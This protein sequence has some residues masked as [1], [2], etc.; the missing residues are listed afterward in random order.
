VNNSADR[1][2]QKEIKNTLKIKS[3]LLNNTHNKNF[4]TN[5]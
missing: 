3:F 4:I 2:M 1:P 5:H